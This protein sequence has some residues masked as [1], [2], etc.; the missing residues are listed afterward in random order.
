MNANPSHQKVGILVI[1][2]CLIL[3][4]ASLP[5]DILITSYCIVLFSIVAF[6]ANGLSKK[7]MPHRQNRSLC[8]SPIGYFDWMTIRLIWDRS[9]NQTNQTLETG[10]S[11][12]V[13]PLIFGSMGTLDP[14]GRDKGFGFLRRQYKMSRLWRFR[15]AAKISFSSITF[16]L[17]Q[18]NRFPN[19]YFYL[20]Q[21][22]KS[23]KISYPGTVLT[24]H[25]FL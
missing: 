4:P 2:T 10:F 12:L 25:M 1:D 19:T 3:V 18:T 8:I 21:K 20:L 22:C 14:P 5:F 7:W 6:F 17:I 13:F 15:K 16:N 24:G 11:Y 23:G 9:P